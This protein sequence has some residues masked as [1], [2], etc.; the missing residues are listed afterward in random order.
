MM[1]R[2]QISME[3]TMLRKAKHRASQLGLSLAAYLRTLI[4]RDLA[5]GRPPS[6]PT[7]IFDLGDSERSDIARFKDEMV[8]EA[9]SA[10]RRR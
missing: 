6:D 5:P 7:S 10:R 3:R 8:G 9:V 2:T 4:E 1:T